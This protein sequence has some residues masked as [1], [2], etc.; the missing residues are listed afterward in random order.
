MKRYKTVLFLYMFLLA[1][2]A[3]FGQN[4]ELSSGFDPERNPS[5]D[6]KLAI[7]IADAENKFIIL[8]VG[9]SWC[10]W[11]RHLDSFI[12]ASEKI[13]VLLNERF[14]L[15][16]VNYSKENKNEE[17]LKLYP[18]IKGFPHFFVLD[19]KGN[20]LESKNTGEL[21]AGESYDEDKIINWLN[22]F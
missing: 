12:K 10:K 4:P 14:I 15:L 19:S 6:L 1:A 11:C 21:E 22:T 2:S 17:F 13:S 3:S 20:L 8:D 18:E 7:K 9:G 5:E 16:K